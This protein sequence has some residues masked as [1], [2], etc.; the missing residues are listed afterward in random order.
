MRDVE[1]SSCNFAAACLANV[2]ATGG[3]LAA[4]LRLNTVIFSD[5]FG[6]GMRIWYRFQRL[7]QV[8]Q[9]RFQ[10]CEVVAAAGRMQVT[11]SRRIR[12]SSPFIL[13]NSP[14]ILLNSPFILLNSPFELSNAS[15]TCAAM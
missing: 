13:L 10:V 4:I 2:D 5:A 7:L 12:L 11:T 14:F 8:R 6:I 1:A 3:R 9:Q 15:T